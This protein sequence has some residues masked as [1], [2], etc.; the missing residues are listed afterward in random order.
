LMKR[1]KVD[2]NGG[3]VLNGPMAVPGGDMIAMCMDP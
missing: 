1:W 3:K 2:E